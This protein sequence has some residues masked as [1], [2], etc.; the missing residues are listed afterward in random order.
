MRGLDLDMTALNSVGT[1]PDTEPPAGLKT[2]F[3][4]AI[5]AAKTEHDAKAGKARGDAYG[6]DVPGKQK[7][8]NAMMRVVETAETFF[9]PAKDEDDAKRI[10]LKYYRA[11][12]IIQDR[13]IDSLNTVRFSIGGPKRNILVLS[14][15][16]DPS[17]RTA[18]ELSA[19]LGLTPADIKA[20]VESVSG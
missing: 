8:V 14:F 10:R 13:G 4:E 16:P 17:P 7:E 11:R 19:E 3:Q 20:L 1:A 6:F 9:I 12:R 15:E 18:E 5:D 2:A